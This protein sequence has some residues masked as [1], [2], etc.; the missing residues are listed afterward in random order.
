MRCP[1]CNEEIE[2]GFLYC[3]KCGEEIRIV[4][5]YN[6][7]V[8]DVLSDSLTDIFT[9]EKGKTE[10]KKKPEQPEQGKAETEEKPLPK[11]RISKKKI[12]V[13][14]VLVL[15]IVG[16]IL[17]FFV[18]GFRSNSYEYQYKRAVA[19]SEDGKY[20]KA[21]EYL[22]RAMELLPGQIDMWKLRAEIAG[23]SGDKQTEQDSYRYILDNLE[24][25]NQEVYIK[26]INL[27]I[28]DGDME[29]VKALLDGCEVSAVR[30]YF[31]DYIAAVP[32]SSFPDGI[33]YD[34]M[35]IELE[36]DGMDI[37][38]T[39]DGTAP[40]KESTKY[41]GP[42]SLQEGKNTIR[43]I[44]VSKKGVQSDEAIFSY[45]ISYLEPEMPEVSPQSGEYPGELEIVVQVPD[46]C[47]VLYTLDGSLPNLESRVYTGPVR[48]QASTIFTAVSVSMNER[49]SDS[50][51]RSYTIL[52]AE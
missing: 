29:Q 36:A 43:A 51:V 17:N 25:G 3:K 26:L 16:L 6:P 8:E 33:Y 38:F 22:D 2:D 48:I 52:P 19:M 34:S 47:T 1:N 23:L 14:L 15:F 45:E 13:I 50:V 24:P 11:K 37:Y 28:E 10:E 35:N 39:T 18:M 40:T 31:R 44:S 21:M 46:G 27:F 41:E 20:D 4:P 12:A 5:D 49:I 9:K 30:N 42:I 32:K 7:L